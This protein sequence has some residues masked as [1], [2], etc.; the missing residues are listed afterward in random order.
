MMTPATL[1]HLAE[2]R[3]RLIASLVVMCVTMA[4]VYAAKEPLLAYLLQ[5]LLN[6]PNAPQT[7]VFSAVPELFFAYLKITVWGGVFL[8]LPV[9]MYQIWRFF[10]PGLYKHERAAVR[11]LLVA[12]PLLF[13]GGGLFAYYAVLPL[14]L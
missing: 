2:L 3:R 11:P 13:Y 8:T 4:G 10:A 14:A 1:K 12:A 7:L 5:P 9:L 6:T